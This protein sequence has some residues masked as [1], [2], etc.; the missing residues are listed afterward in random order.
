MEWRAVAIT[1]EESSL[2]RLRRR[3]IKMSL[4]SSSISIENILATTRATLCLIKILSEF[5]QQIDE[6]KKSKEL[7]DYFGRVIS[8]LEESDDDYENSIL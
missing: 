3:C 2:V 5:L 1:S 8:K 7:S 4:D 6:K